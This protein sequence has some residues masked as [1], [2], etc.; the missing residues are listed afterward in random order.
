MIKHV[1]LGEQGFSIVELLVATVV[2]PLMVGTLSVAYNAVAHS[3]MVARQLNEMYAVL[4]A[5]P[6]LD[7]AHEFGSLSSTSNCYPNNSF[8]SE[9]GG[10]ATVS[11]TP[12]LTVTDTPNLTSSDPL[13]TIPDSKV[14]SISVGYPAPNTSLAPL[15]LRMLITRNGIGQQ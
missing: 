14:V 12:T 10:T 4:S 3:Y 13:Q 8:P 9:N 2:F 1:R 7:R 15:Q 5:C 6:E 11:Y